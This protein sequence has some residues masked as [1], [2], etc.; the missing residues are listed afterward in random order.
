MLKNKYSP[1]TYSIYAISIILLQFSLVIAQPMP[2]DQFV[3]QTKKLFYDSGKDW[4]SLTNFGP[5]RYG[6]EGESKS[7]KLDNHILKDGDILFTIADKFISINGFGRLKYNDHFYAYFYPELVDEIGENNQ[8]VLRTSFSGNYGSNSGVG[9]EN[10]WGIF[11]IGKGK[12]N[13]GA[14][15]DIQIALSN[16]SSSYNYFL[17]GSDYGRIRVRYIYG[18]LEKIENVNRY[19]TARGLEYTNKR[20]LVI[21]FSETVIYSGENRSFDI[22]Y[23]NP[24]SSHLEIELNN[25]LNV[26]GDGNSNAVWQFHLDF[27]P[28][29]NFRFS[30]NFLYDE[31]VLDPDIQIGKENGKAFSS[32]MAYSPAISNKYLLTLYC[33]IINVGTPTFRHGMGTN[34]FIQ[35]GRPLGWIRGSDGQ[36]IC[37]GINYFNY[38]NLITSFSFGIM[39]IGEESIINRVFD[40]YED[41][42]EG[43]FPSGKVDKSY[44]FS[45]EISYQWGMNYSLSTKIQRDKNINSLY[46]K[47]NIP[48][49]Q[50][51]QEQL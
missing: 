30:L 50:S 27:L 25:R 3:Y 49:F 26:V 45:A 35:S 12:E 39:E 42:L 9:F 16:H 7:H 11:Q 21:G 34:N 2:M 5:L 10:S 43:K 46:L 15:N 41:Y 22:G 32:R 13:W 51:L 48:I 44:F 33:S 37:I 18:F 6:L 23:L 28:A 14:G 47:L 4:H 1:F 31:L 8:P 40:P 24:I 29:K 38:K 19:I 17:L 36:E 20:S